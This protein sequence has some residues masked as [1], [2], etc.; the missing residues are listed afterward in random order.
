MKNHLFP[1]DRILWLDIR[2]RYLR[3]SLLYPCFL[4]LFCACEKKLSDA[5]HESPNLLLILV[6][7]MGYGDLSSAG[8]PHLKTPHLDALAAKSV[9]FEHFYVSPVCAPTRA[10]L[11]TGRYP[12]RS[13]VY[14][15]T[16]G[17]ESMAPEA[18]TLG[19]LLQPL[20][21]RTGL[22]GKWHLGEY[23]PMTPQAQGFDEF[24]GFRTGH[25][26][27]YFDP[28][29]EHNGQD[30]A[31]RGYITDLLTQEAFA[32]MEK[33][34]APFFCF[35][36]LNAPHTPLQIDSSYYTHFLEQGLNERTARVYGMVENIDQNIGQLLDQLDQIDKLKETIVVFM[37]DNGPISG[38]RVPQ[39]KMRYNAGLRDQKFTIYEGGI[40]TQSFWH[41][42]DQ[43]KPKTVKQQLAAHIDL[44]PTFLD[45]L[46]RKNNSI[47]QSELDGLSLLP[48]LFNE[49][50]PVS[51]RDRL[52]LQ[53][54]HL[55]TLENPAP[56]PGGIALQWP[57]KMAEDSLLFHLSQDPAEAKNIATEHPEKLQILRQAYLDWW[58]SLPHDTS[59]FA[60]AI[61]IGHAAENPVLLQPH[62]GKSM[63][64]VKFLGQRGLLGERIGSHPSGVD[65]DWLGE[66][67]VK[68]D[69]ARW[70][71]DVQRAGAYEISVVVR[72]NIGEG[73]ARFLVQLAEDSISVVLPQPKPGEA[74]QEVPLFD[75]AL[76]PGKQTTSIRLQSKLPAEN[77]LELRGLSLRRKS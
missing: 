21:Y 69:G 41:W 70:L 19:E 60:L 56:F 35:L 76:R 30:Q 33:T 6:D 73:A 32:F 75:L 11:L 53:Q 2:S 36:S 55:S 4:L 71:L 34:D 72:G 29:L 28:I 57:F 52:I 48:V 44:A 51:L 8:N 54:F 3:I 45:L 24:V 64:T 40:R 43:W 18:I 16:N 42:P 20:G 10:S 62:H 50:V 15:V 49:E 17:F 47:E 7:D 59:S 13:G 9:S 31:Y 39:E 22:F 14:S 38:W 25:H 37:S 77:K 23:Y 46:S 68:G 74:W 63:G 61:P 65:G 1:T 12:Q 66:W 5:S 26:A 58:Q 67:E 27:D